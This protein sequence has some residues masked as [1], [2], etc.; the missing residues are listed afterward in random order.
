VV[1]AAF[2]TPQQPNSVNT[3]RRI[4]PCDEPPASQRGMRALQ[5]RCEPFGG[6]NTPRWVCVLL[7]I[8]FG[9]LN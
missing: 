6:V 1:C 5:P 7:A 2:N 3:L 9:E 8:W 4:E